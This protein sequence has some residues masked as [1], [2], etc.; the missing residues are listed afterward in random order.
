VLGCHFNHGERRECVV[1]ILTFSRTLKSSVGCLSL[2]QMSEASEVHISNLLLAISDYICLANIL[3]I[4][5]Q[6]R[7]KS[8]D[9]YLP[10]VLFGSNSTCLEIPPIV[11]R[12]FSLVSFHWRDSFFPQMKSSF[13]HNGA[14]LQQREKLPESCFESR[15]YPMNSEASK[16]TVEFMRASTDVKLSSMTAMVVALVSSSKSAQLRCLW[17]QVQWPAPKVEA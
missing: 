2:R 15:L 4:R 7:V 17:Q 13:P 16:R 11:L 14:L 5:E 6:N 3:Q 9:L 1:L 8:L 10:P 12:L